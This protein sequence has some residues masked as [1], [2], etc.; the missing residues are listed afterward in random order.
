MVLGANILAKKG[1]KGLLKEHALG[2]EFS[3]SRVLSCSLGMTYPCCLRMGQGEV[4]QLASFIMKTSW[5]GQS[6]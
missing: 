4:R 2:T 1:K 3:K 5:R 6:P